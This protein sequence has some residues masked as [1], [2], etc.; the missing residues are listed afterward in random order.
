M[1]V[2]YL[3]GTALDDPNPYYNSEIL[4]EPISTLETQSND[5]AIDTLRKVTPLARHHVNFYGRYRFD[6]DLRP[7]KVAA[8]A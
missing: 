1:R 6:S 8:F 2:C 3:R 4:S 7:I 5:A